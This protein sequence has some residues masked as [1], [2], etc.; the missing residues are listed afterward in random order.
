MTYDDLVT[1]ERGLF[2][3]ALTAGIENL[4]LAIQH[5]R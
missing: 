2:V 5:Y 3:L 1:M 4:D